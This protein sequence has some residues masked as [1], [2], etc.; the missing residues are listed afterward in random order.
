[1]QHQPGAA[2]D[3]PQESRQRFARL[4]KLGEDENLLL[5]GGDDFDELAQARE[6]AAVV[7]VPG[8]VAEPLRGVVANLLEAHQERQH[9]ALARDAVG[10]FERCAEV[11]DRALI[12]RCLRRAQRAPGLELGL[13]GQVGNHPFVGLQA[14]Q[15]VRANQIAQ[16][17]VVLVLRQAPGEVAE[18]L[19]RSEQSGVSEVE[20]RPQVR[21]AILDRRPGQRDSRIGL[22]LLDLPRLPGSRVL[23]RLR[24]VDD[25]QAPVDCFERRQA[26]E[27]PVARHHQIEVGELRRVEFAQARRRH[28]RRVG[29]EQ[30]QAGRKAFGLGRPVGHQRGG[31]DQQ[32]GAARRRL[33][34][35]FDDQQQREDLDR[36]AESHVVGQAG[37]ESQPGEQVEPANAGLLVGAQIGLELVARIDLRQPLGLAQAVQ[38]FGEPGTG[39]DCRPVGVGRLVASSERRAGHQPH[40]FGKGNAAVCRGALR[41]LETVEQALEALAVELD[42]TPADQLQTVAALEQ[43]L[44]LGGGKRLAVERD[45]HVEVEQGVHAEQRGR[46]FAD[47]DADLRSRRAA[48]EP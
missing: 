15:D 32:A 42:P 20:D 6:F 24:F 36:L 19:A 34:L 48:G 5:L 27:R 17:A 39:G 37:A 47:A 38:S 26:N 46:L 13:V 8:R 43:R 23:D 25:R 41:G 14:A 31:D 21:Q 33:L 3:R 30:P 7:G 10:R 28:R 45:V 29:D 44:D 12:E 22:E 1:M 35:A 4:A 9:D 18:D 16:R 40:R 11:L 2:E